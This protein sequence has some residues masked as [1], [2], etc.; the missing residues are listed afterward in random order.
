[1]IVAAHSLRACVF[2]SV[3][4]SVCG[5]VSSCIRACCVLRLTS[6]LVHSFTHSMIR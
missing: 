4:V 2:V 5:V 3:S 1:M 6:S